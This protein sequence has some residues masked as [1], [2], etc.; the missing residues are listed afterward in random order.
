VQN[1]HSQQTADF[2]KIDDIIS[3]VNAHQTPA[4]AGDI[5]ARS[6]WSPTLDLSDGDILKNCIE[7]IAYS[8]QAQAMR[9]TELI[10][11]GIFDKVFLN[12][13]LDAVANL[14][15]EQLHTKYWNQIGAIR[16]PQKLEAMIG[17]AQA[18]LRIKKQHSSFM[19]YL[20]SSKLP[21]ALVN[22]SDIDVFWRE[23]TAVQQYLQQKQMPFFNKLTSLCHLLMTLGYACIKPDSA[24]MGAA[25][26]IGIVSS[27][28]NPEK[29]TYNDAKRREV[30]MTMQNYCLSRNFNI[31]VL[32]GYLLIYGGQT[33]AKALVVP[34]FY[35]FR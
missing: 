27:G 3:R 5:A 11:K 21:V 2:K 29:P 17:C 9:V 13:D 24:V 23:F 19:T 16:F 7:L 34:Q 35:D 8:Q 10:D 14:Q 31:R 30:V 4:L 32:D 28:N 20:R 22:Q 25:V 18:L 6:K 26:K 1:N 33:G 12:Y 15:H